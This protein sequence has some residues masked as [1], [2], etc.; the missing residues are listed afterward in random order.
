MSKFSNEKTIRIKKTR[1]KVCI[2]LGNPV[3]W[4]IHWIRCVQD[5]WPVEYGAERSLLARWRRRVGSFEKVTMLGSIDHGVLD[6]NDSDCSR[7]AQ[8]ARPIKG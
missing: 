5:G 8:V 2:Q 1:T 6:L 4:K 3:Q 7:S